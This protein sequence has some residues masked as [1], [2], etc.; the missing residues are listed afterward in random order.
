[1]SVN[2]DLD[3]I[4]FCLDARASSLLIGSDSMRIV[5]YVL[6][7]VLILV[8]ISFALLN[9]HT[10][11]LDYFIGKTNIYFPL[12]FVLLLLCGAILGIL[13]L[14]PLLI[15]SQT[16]IHRLKHKMKILDQEVA[17][18]RRIPIKDSH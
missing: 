15:R 9:S 12:L 13:A 8:G 1:M 16:T 5:T 14:I 4:K 6:W 18:L 7:I 10:L 2:A 3:L 11:P 17:N